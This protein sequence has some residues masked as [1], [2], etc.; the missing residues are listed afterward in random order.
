MPDTTE[1]LDS[2]SRITRELKQ[3]VREELGDTVGVDEKTVDTLVH[4]IIS[5]LPSAHKSPPFRA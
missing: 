3:L 4:S 1:P 5:L 2:D